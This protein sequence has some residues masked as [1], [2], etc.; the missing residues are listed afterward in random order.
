[1]FEWLENTADAAFAVTDRG[2]ICFWSRAAE[3]L[4]GYGAEEALGTGSQQLLCG[5]GPLGTEIATHETLLLYKDKTRANISDFDM[6]V[7]AKGGQDLWVNLSTLFYDDPRTCRTVVVHLARDITPRKTRERLI[8]TVLRV[9]KQLDATGGLGRG[10]QPIMP[11]SQQERRIL[12][13]V[14]KGKSSREVS[15]ELDISPQTLRNH[16]HHVNQKL[17][18]HNRVEAVR[19]ALERR[20]I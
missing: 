4:F 7:K 3:R 11:L 1:M 19:H 14:W 2:E 10:A 8:E 15:R 12:E 20:L 18:T 16:L 6:L 17:H 5:R 9:F 13:M